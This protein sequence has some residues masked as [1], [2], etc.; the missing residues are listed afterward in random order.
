MSGNDEIMDYRDLLIEIRSK[1]TTSRV[2]AMVLIVILMTFDYVISVVRSFWETRVFSDLMLLYLIILLILLGDLLLLSSRKTMFHIL[3]L[4]HRVVSFQSARSWNSRLYFIARILLSFFS[5]FLIVLGI[6]VGSTWTH[7][8]TYQNVLL[9]AWI[10]SLALFASIVIFSRL[11]R[12]ISRNRDKK[13]ESEEKPRKKTFKDLF[14]PFVTSLIAYIM[15]YFLDSIIDLILPSVSQIR[16]EVI[17]SPAVVLFFTSTMTFLAIMTFAWGI[18]TLTV[19]IKER[20]RLGGQTLPSGHVKRFFSR[21]WGNSWLV[22]GSSFLGSL[23]LITMTILADTKE[24]SLQSFT[25]VVSWT[26]TVFF[27][28]L[29]APTSIPY[30]QVETLAVSSLA[31]L[32]LALLL[33]SLRPTQAASEVEGINFSR[34]L[35]ITCLGGTIYSLILLQGYALSSIHGQL[36]TINPILYLIGLSF[37]LFIA[38][39]PYFFT[40]LHVNLETTLVLRRHYSRD[41]LRFK[42]HYKGIFF[43]KRSLRNSFLLQAFIVIVFT[44]MLAP[45]G[46]ASFLQE[47]LKVIMKELQ[48]INFSAQS[49]LT[50]YLSGPFMFIRVLVHGYML[51]ALFFM[52]FEVPARELP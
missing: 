48:D 31:A 12:W 14:I 43:D 22:G 27:P 51:L 30:A 29:Y 33:I 6:I 34:L 47:S 18:Q 46:N 11:L 36:D 9:L 39:S 23:F 41:L 40:L 38:F 26:T 42:Q 8:E 17:F 10:V 44:F 16:K 28:R 1:F 20:R 7:L 35:N 37:A 5:G 21:K 4:G 45:E 52:R 3:L 15:R 50:I 25:D 19:I 32:V 24:Q 2:L 13:E 49:I